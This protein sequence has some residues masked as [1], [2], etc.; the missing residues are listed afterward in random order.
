MSLAPSAL[1]F[2]NIP[3]SGKQGGLEKHLGLNDSRRFPYQ[4]GNWLHS[5]VP[6]F[7]NTSSD[8]RKA[9]CIYGKTAQPTSTNK[10]RNIFLSDPGIWGLG[11]HI[12]SVYCWDL[13]DVTLAKFA[14]SAS[15]STWWPKLYPMLVE[16]L[17]DQYI[18]KQCIAMDEASYGAKMCL[19]NVLF[20]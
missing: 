9:K 10:I 19:C 8:L 4:G 16:P 17:G 3:M 14:I 7:W 12:L 6:M 20:L 13:T 11:V 2:A 1:R 5:P 15:S 18:C